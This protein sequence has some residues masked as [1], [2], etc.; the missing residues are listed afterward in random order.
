MFF[1]NSIFKKVELNPLL[2]TVKRVLAF[3]GGLFLSFS[4]SN[5]DGS[6]IRLSISSLQT[7]EQGLD[8]NDFI[9]K[10]M[11]FWYFW[12]PNVKDLGDNRFENDQEYTEFLKSES[13]SETFLRKLLFEDDRFTFWNEDYEVLLNSLSGVSKSNGLQF[14]IIDLTADDT[15]NLFGFIRNVVPGSTAAEAGLERGDIFYGVNGQVLTQD[16]YTNLLF[17]DSS[18]Y[19]LNMGEADVTNRLVNQTEEEITLSKIENFQEDPIRLAT[20]LDIN[21]QK[22]GYL[23]YRQFNR[24]FNSELNEVFGQFVANGVTDLVLDMR[25]NGGGSVNTSRLL[26][27]MIYGTNT[28]E[29]Y[30]R[31]RWNDRQQER[32]SDDQLEDFFANQ[33]S[34]G[35]KLNSLN[36]SRVFVLGT[37]RT[38]SASELV[39]NGLDP[40]IE[41]IHVGTTTRG[42]N[43]FSISLVDDPSNN[44]IYSSSRE[45]NINPNNSWIVQPLVGRNENAVGFFDYTAGFSPDIEIAEDVFNLGTFGDPNEPL[46]ARAIEEIT[47][48][49]GK[50]ASRSRFQEDVRY[51]EFDTP[52]LELMVL[53]KPLKL[54]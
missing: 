26:A 44:Y 52:E 22:I 4:C 3:F 17:D 51:R 7:T 38:A 35:E 42:K 12:Q 11:N 48:I 50:E 2:T 10:A 13:N 6:G 36:L 5:D 46:L 34:S 21:G 20:T 47:G 14:F 25:Y 23:M 24:N 29:L 33:V 1:N 43:E 45:A 16:N 32:F 19:A 18:S 53:D 31:Q 27:S 8:T 9:W 41:V 54:K 39:M 40:Y 49:S 37:N 30:V 28:E 15:D